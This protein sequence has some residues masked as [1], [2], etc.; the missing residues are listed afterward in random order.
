MFFTGFEIHFVSFIYY[1]SGSH[2]REKAIVVVS[3]ATHNIKI[4]L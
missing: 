3:E 4:S 2:V 1:R